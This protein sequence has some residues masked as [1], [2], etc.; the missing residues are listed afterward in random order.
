MRPHPGLP[1][2]GGEP[3]GPQVERGAVTDGECHVVQ[4]DSGFVERLVVAI[5]MLRQRE[6]GRDSEWRRN[7]LR[8]ASSD[9]V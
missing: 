9:D 7:T 3:F 4:A 5:A 8:N 1:P 2:G 6:A